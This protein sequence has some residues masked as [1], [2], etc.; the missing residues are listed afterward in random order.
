MQVFME[1]IEGIVSGVTDGYE[2]PDVGGEKRTEV[3]RRGHTYA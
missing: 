1:A 2:L 3:L